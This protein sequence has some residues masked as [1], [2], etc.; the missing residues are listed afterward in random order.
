M[1]P[2]TRDSSRLMWRPSA[3]CLRF[4]KGRLEGFGHIPC[5]AFASGHGR[6]SW[7]DGSWFVRR[8]SPTS[9]IATEEGSFED[10]DFEGH[11]I[12]H[13]ADATEFEGLWSK[14]AVVGPGAWPPPIK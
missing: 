1:V 8:V 10:G 3:L 6:K 7:S 9:L 13:Y 14:S 4:L 2:P 11:G 12:F 5:D